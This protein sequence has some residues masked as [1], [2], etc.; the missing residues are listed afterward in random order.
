MQDKSLLSLDEHLQSYT[1]LAIGEAGI[2]KLSSI[3]LSVQLSMFEAQIELSE[4]YE[5]PIIIHCV[6]SWNELYTLQRKHKPQMPWIIHGF[7]K[8]PKLAHELLSKGHYLSFGRYAYPE[9][10]RLAFDKGHLFLETDDQQEVYIPKIYQDTAQIL[11][12]RLEKLIRSIEESAN[13][14]FF[15]R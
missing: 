9:S 13:K 10:I 1:P 6:R 11:G 4:Q 3:P 14:V 15:N 12:I 2:D 7:R 8:Q 5:L